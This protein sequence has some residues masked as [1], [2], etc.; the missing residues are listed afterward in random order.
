M[1]ELRARMPVVLN[2]ADWAKWLGE[3]PATEDELYALLRPCPDETL[4]IW[5]VD[6]KVGN[7]RSTGPQLLRP[8]E[9]EPMRL[10]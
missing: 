8:I 3:K 7:V 4:K 2:E 10:I 9:S 1:A 6:N 5:P